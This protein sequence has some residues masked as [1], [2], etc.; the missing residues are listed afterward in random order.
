M[1][2]PALTAVRVFVDGKLCELRADYTGP[3]QELLRDGA[4]G[5]VL[6]SQGA[7]YR[8]TCEGLDVDGPG[9]AS[10]DGGVRAPMPGRIVSMTAKIGD[11]VEAGVTL[12]VLEAMKMEHSLT[13]PFAGEIVEVA[14][15]QGDQVAEGTVLVRVSAKT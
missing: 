8:L 14:A 4:G 9:A 12:A 13:A 1:N 5:F 11:H 2:A 15:A 7:P 10:G 6:F 3:A